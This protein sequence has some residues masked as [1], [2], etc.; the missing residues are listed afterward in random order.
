LF[1]RLEF[2][3]VSVYRMRRPRRETDASLVFSFFNTV[4]LTPGTCLDVQVSV[5]TLD[6]RK[7]T[8]GVFDDATKNIGSHTD[9]VS[10]VFRQADLRD[11]VAQS[12]G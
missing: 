4:Q 7:P 6:R 10:F 11:Q 2:L 3:S 12:C 5:P 1:L 9:A 8:S